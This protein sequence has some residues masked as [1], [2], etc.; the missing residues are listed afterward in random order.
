MINFSCNV[1]L[2]FDCRGLFSVIEVVVDACK[3]RDHDG[4]VGGIVVDPL[5][6]EEQQQFH[7]RLRDL[8]KEF[9]KF[10]SDQFNLTLQKIDNG[11]L[12]FETLSDAEL[13]NFWRKYCDQQL[14]NKFVRELDKYGSCAYQVE[15]KIRDDVYAD[16]KEYFDVAGTTD[17]EGRYA[18]HTEQA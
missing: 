9:S 15:L 6:A 1:P 7:S 10:F 12:I 8:Q 5:S 3:I 11:K 14:T 16:L 2:T 4:D 18:D 17:Q 13:G